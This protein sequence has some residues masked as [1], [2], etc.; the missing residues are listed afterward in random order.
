MPKQRSAAKADPFSLHASPTDRRV[1]AFLARPAARH[2]SWSSLIAKGWLNGCET[3]LWYTRLGAG[4]GTTLPVLSC[5]LV[6]R[7]P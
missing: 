5:I 2:R 7:R 3:P 6:R 1:S 4:I